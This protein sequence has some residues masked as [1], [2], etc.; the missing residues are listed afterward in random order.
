MLEQ[1]K[2]QAYAI[3]R[4]LPPET[5]VKFISQTLQTDV[6]MSPS[7][8]STLLDTLSVGSQRFTMADWIDRVLIIQ[9]ES[10]V[11][12]LAAISILS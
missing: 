12:S 4:D 9:Q 10:G 1:A 7:Q 8:L 5:Q 6:W 2:S 3:L 11:R